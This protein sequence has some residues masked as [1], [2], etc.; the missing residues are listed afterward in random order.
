MVLAVPPKCAVITVLS[1][2]AATPVSQSL[3]Q[4]SR[5]PCK[6]HPAGRCRRLPL[7]VLAL[8]HLIHSTCR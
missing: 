5:R 2:L 7:P 3:L 8:I 6:C 1:G 4:A